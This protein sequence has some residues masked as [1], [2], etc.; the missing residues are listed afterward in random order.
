MFDAIKMLSPKQRL[1]GLVIIALISAATSLGTAYMSGSDCT[2]IS[3]KYTKSVENY[4][5]S[6]ENYNRLVD[7]TD[8]TQRKYLKARQDILLM[9]DQLKAISEI[10]EK[11][12]IKTGTE[13]IESNS[14]HE[15]APASTN[16]DGDMSEQGEEDRK[17][18]KERITIIKTE[19]PKA[20]KRIIDSLIQMTKKYE[21]NK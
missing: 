4:T 17:S 19:T 3:A 1:L 8:E 21:N 16:E 13:Y 10:M 20:A 5:K 7:I 18:I 12:H 9:Q 15:R 11:K 6:I 14:R 2:E